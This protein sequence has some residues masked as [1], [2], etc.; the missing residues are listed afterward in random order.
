MPHKGRITGETL[1]QLMWR[2]QNK[3]HERR[4]FLTTSRLLKVEPPIPHLTAASSYYQT[5]LCEEEASRRWWWTWRNRSCFFEVKDAVFCFQQIT[6]LKSKWNKYIMTKRPLRKFV[7]TYTIGPYNCTHH[8]H[9]YK[10][11]P[12][13][14]NI[15][16]YLFQ[17]AVNTVLY[18]RFQTPHILT[19]L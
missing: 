1:D 2:H 19:P 9:S 16:F 12:V 13:P 6:F 15:Y 10:I 11:R 17:V 18:S 3:T 7:G 14:E 8:F 4:L 5:N